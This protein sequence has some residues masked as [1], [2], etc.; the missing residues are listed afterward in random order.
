MNWS[1]GELISPGVRL[2]TFFAMSSFFS[3]SSAS[4][5]LSNEE[6]NS[7]VRGP[8]SSRYCISMSRGWAL[9]RSQ[10][11]HTHTPSFVSSSVSCSIL[12]AWY[13]CPTFA[14]EDDRT[15]CLALSAA[16]LSCSDSPVARTMDCCLPAW[17]MSDILS[18][19]SFLSAVVSASISLAAPDSTVY[20]DWL[21]G[22]VSSCLGLWY[23]TIHKQHENLWRHLT[24]SI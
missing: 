18:S 12:V 3:S 19:A 23:H 4:S 2:W 21:G 7:T 24:R 6:E 20:P 15:R 16:A 22:S 11:T 14:T 9:F 1:A 17:V 8:I 5:S 13:L 10:H